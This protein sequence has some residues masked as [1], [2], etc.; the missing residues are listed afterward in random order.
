MLNM[1]PFAAGG[2]RRF[3]VPEDWEQQRGN[4]CLDWPC[5]LVS[6][7]QGPDSWCAQ[8]WLE[9]PC[10]GRLNMVREPDAHNYGVHNDTL[11]AVMDTGFGSFLYSA[12][13]ALN[14][15]FLPSNDGAFGRKIIQAADTFRKY[16][17]SSHPVFQHFAEIVGHEK[18]LSGPEIASDSFEHIVWSRF[19]AFESFQTSGQKVGMCR[20]F[21]LFV[22]LR[23]LFDDWTSLLVVLIRA[24]LDEP[25]MSSRQYCEICRA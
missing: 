24:N 3:Q 15:L 25:W 2:L 14:I 20:W 10:H 11:G 22:S 19:L 18:G 1:T 23:R 16:S 13:V 5:L 17:S 9:S 21:Q 8:A 4:D 7:D 12:T 6:A